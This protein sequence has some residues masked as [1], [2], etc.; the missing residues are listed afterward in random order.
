MSF[1]KNTLLVFDAF[2]ADPLRPYL[3]R[4][5][6]RKTKLSTTAVKAA[7]D[8][9]IQTGVIIKIGR[10][11]GDGAGFGNGS[12]FGSGSGSG[13]G[14]VDGSGDGSG[15]GSGYAYG[16]YTTYLANWDNP[17]FKRLMKSRT[18]DLISESG[19]L[20][21]LFDSCQP[22]AVVI[23][24]SALRGEDTAQSDIDL[25]VQAKSRKVDLSKYEKALGRSIQPLFEPDFDKIGKELRN[26][27]INGVVLQGYLKVF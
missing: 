14:F 8:E 26:N 20:D 19:L 1:S 15:Y 6:S 18:L 25:Y 23:Y 9:L 4:E 24:G 21:Y 12:G 2:H 27:I 11:R 3:L 10:T 16:S 22:S 13:P 5:L 17:A 7:L